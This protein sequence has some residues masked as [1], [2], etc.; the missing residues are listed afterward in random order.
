[1]AGSPV[2]G[3]PAF[4][5]P[6]SDAGGDLYLMDFIGMIGIPLVPVSSYPADAK[7]IFLPS[8]AASETG[9]LEKVKN[10]TGSGTRVILTSGF[11][12]QAGSGEEIAGL[13]GIRWP[14]VKNPGK[15]KPVVNQDLTD[16]TDMRVEIE[17]DMEIS[18]ASVLLEVDMDG[19]RIPYL[20]VSQD[21]TVF[22]LNAHTFSQADFDAAGEVLLCPGPLGLMDIPDD[23]A[24]TIRAVFNN[25]LGINLD[26]P[27]R[28][29]CQPFGKNELMIQNYNRDPV[30]VRLEIDENFNYYNVLNGKG[31][32]KE[33]S[34]L[35][36]DL[37]ARSRIWIK[38]NSD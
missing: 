2:E 17:A 12:L 16:S 14:L 31:L 34:A 29:S 25:P 9:I 36:L 27:V 13:A 10:S 5:P 19:K 37:P 7:V 30:K 33:G 22:V 1:I 20:T 3:V 24:N 28:V 23:W 18:T 4:K 8:Q 15:A 38:S 35:N 21:G 26:A 32:P 11:L 6:N